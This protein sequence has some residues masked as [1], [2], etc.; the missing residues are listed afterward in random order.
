[1][2]IHFILGRAGAGKTRRCLDE[3]RQEL[4][5]DR[6]GPALVLLVP[7]QASFH[8]ER[9]LLSVPGVGASLRAE[10]L[11]FRRLA[12]RVAGET[13]VSALDPLGGLE[14]LLLLRSILSA[15]RGE[16]VRYGPLWDRP[17]LAAELLSLFSEFARH[18][19]SPR[20]LMEFTARLGQQANPPRGLIDKLADVSL[21]WDDYRRAAGERDSDLA[22]DTLLAALEKTDWPAGARVW[23]DG[24]STFSPAEVAVLQSLA[25][26]CEVVSVSLC[27][28]PRRLDELPDDPRQLDPTRLFYPTESTYLQLSML[29]RGDD[30]HLEGAP[31]F[32]V[33]SP[34]ARLEASLA[35]DSEATFEPGDALVVRPAM[36]PREEI[37][38]AA[39]DILRLVHDEGMRY[40]QIAIVAR[41]VEDYADHARMILGEAGIPFFLDR[42]LPQ[43]THPLFVLVR[44]GLETIL[45]RTHGSMRD[46]LKT[47]LS[48]LTADAADRLE[49]FLFERGLDG[50]G[51]LEKPW[52][53][54][55]EPLRESLLALSREILAGETDGAAFAAALFEWTERLHAREALEAWIEE[56]GGSDPV[57]RQAWE[58]FLELLDA[59][60][61]ALGPKAMRAEAWAD[62]LLAALGDLHCALVPP[63]LDQVLFGSIERS[64]HP[65]LDV[66]FFVGM[67]E[68]SMPRLVDS[69]G[70]LTEDDRRELL[71]EGQQV[72]P[73]AGRRLAE[74]AYLAY[75]AETRASRRLV[76]SWPRYDG[77]GRETVRSRWID[78]L[79]LRAPDALV[80]SAPAAAVG[81]RQELAQCL[82][83]LSD[84]DEPEAR[85]LSRLAGLRAHTETTELAHR[86]AAGLW[87]RDAA[88]LPE[89]LA[90]EVVDAR[91]AFSATE[92]ECYGKCPFLHFAEKRLRLT[93][94]A[95]F[96]VEPRTLGSLEHAL[97][98]HYG[99]I[100][101]D[102]DGDWSQLTEDECGE[103]VVRV[104]RD[105]A[106]QQD[107][108]ELWTG[109]ARNRHLLERRALELS[110]V[111]RFF[112]DES[113]ATAFRTRRVEWEFG[114]GEAPACHLRDESGVEVGFAG[115]VDRVDSLRS[116]EVT[117]WRVVDYKSRLPRFGAAL[118]ESGVALQLP[119]YMLAIESVRGSTRCA[120]AFYLPLR[121]ARP[122]C[123]VPR[124]E[125]SPGAVEDAFQLRGFF[126]AEHR[127]LFDPALGP[128][129]SS[130]FVKLRL[131]K[132]GR[133]SKGSDA[134]SAAET[135]GLRELARGTLLRIA[136][137]MRAG[138]IEPAPANMNPG[139]GRPE[140]PCLHCAYTS[141]CR[142]DRYNGEDEA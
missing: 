29:P 102:R 118:V 74:E 60:P 68:G 45:G 122:R 134:I 77:N 59:L 34:L 110:C 20:S 31:R 23:V 72:A 101:M 78:R 124:G 70:I 106:R 12:Y 54:E 15:R 91:D 53:R 5:R 13:G 83:A 121:N 1:M 93:E 125:G 116:G 109:V 90:A 71:R 140:L 51:A 67:R 81:T 97:F 128:Q 96:R 117:L 43:S 39:A 44:A 61:S 94:R 98:E 88:M 112:A 126:D 4:L 46:L 52:A 135:D 108:P 48:G 131:N 136:H 24:F 55:S 84:S 7:E 36:S 139:R 47:G 57:H 64:R 66:V 56:A 28:D 129:E 132:D 14:R 38:A 120:G 65:D 11:S 95:E 21:V 82:L 18:R 99:R 79:L 119:L 2:S 37:A 58:A 40:R 75:I 25:Q 138:R 50:A 17:A 115:K 3:I 76:V 123:S 35:E 87:H 49:N 33:D 9:A 105:L 85:E 27:L 30:V 86:A 142:Y 111:L 41:D 104:L 8:T 127:A 92:M 42:R 137:D 73:D 133:V 80:E 113:R 89:T 114:R 26:R 10:V 100:V 63:S 130:R 22:L 6:R 16:L 141:V 69:A 32:V 19:Q 107:S 103:G 62:C